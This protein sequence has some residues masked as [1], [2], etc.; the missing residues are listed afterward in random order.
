MEFGHLLE[1][2]EVLHAVQMLG[3]SFYLDFRG[4]GRIFLCSEF[5]VAEDITD[6]KV[7]AT[8]SK[9]KDPLATTSRSPPLVCSLQARLKRWCRDRTE[10]LYLDKFIEK[11]LSTLQTC[12]IRVFLFAAHFRSCERQESGF[13]VTALAPVVGKKWTP[14]TEWW[15]NCDG[16]WSPGRTVAIAAIAAIAWPPNSP[17]APRYSN[18]HDPLVRGWK[19]EASPEETVLKEPMGELLGSAI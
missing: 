13:A 11:M 1:G 17:A 8:A 18:P 5:W 9:W 12:Q 7:A 4:F 19:G 6:G 2:V 14:R 3:I 10:S 15:K 16:G